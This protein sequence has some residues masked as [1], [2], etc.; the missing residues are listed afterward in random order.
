MSDLTY[1]VSVSVAGT[2]TWTS[3]NDGL[4]YNAADLLYNQQRS[5]T[6]QHKD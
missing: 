3:I 1:G 6:W 4:S 5:V 2:N